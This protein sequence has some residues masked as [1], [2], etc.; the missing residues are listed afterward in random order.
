MSTRKR[1]APQRKPSP[2]KG[3]RVP[4]K[5][6]RK[7]RPTPQPSDMPIRAE[8]RLKLINEASGVGILEIS[9]VNGD[10]QHPNNRFLLTPECRRILGIL[11]DSD[12]RALEQL[13]KIMDPRDSEYVNTTFAA[14]IQDRTGKT[15]CVLEYRV[16]GPS[17]EA[18]WIRST[19]ATKRDAS[20]TAIHFVCALRDIHAEKQNVLSL[21]DAM[22]R[23]ELINKA[24]S[25][26]LWDMT[27][28]PGA[29]IGPK[30]E[31]W[32][33]AQFRKM[34]GYGDEKDFAS[35]LDSFTSRL[36]PRDKERVHNAFVA[37]LKD[38]SGRTPYDIEYQLQLKNGDY[39]WFRSTGET[40]RDQNGVPLRVAGALKDIH[41]EKETAIALES[42]ITAAV[43]GDFSKRMSS[44]L[45]RGPMRTIGDSMNRLLDSTS[46]SF[47][48][49]KSAIEQ[50]GQASAQLRATSQMMSQSSLELN[51]GVDRSSGELSRVADGVKGNAGSAVMANQ[52]V[53]ETAVAARGGAQRMEEMSQA[54]SAI[55]VSSVQIARIIKVI[56]EIAFQTNLL[57]LNAAVEAARA[58]R[59]G[60]GFAVVAQ[61]V[62]SLA[63][64]S[65][66]AAKETA[67]L[68]E[69]S[70]AKVDQG[71]KIAE[72]TRTALRNI[73]GNVTKVVDLAG[74]IASASGEQSQALAS[75][76][77]SMRQAT[78]AAQAGS[79][80][81]NE[82]AA[83]ADELSRQMKLLKERMDRYR[84]GA[85][86][87]T[88]LPGLPAAATPELIDQIIAAL[89]ARAASEGGAVANDGSVASPPPSS[90]R[91]L[92][93]TDD[94]GPRVALPLDRDERGFN[95]F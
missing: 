72:S 78:T 61:E 3:G 52:L 63:E 75:V 71:V 42:L 18:R 27:V 80:Q 48:Y 38:Q 58:G 81:S 86:A 6:E 90:T 76:T 17:G 92:T 79:Q 95:G 34:I 64:R 23:F 60:R 36:H 49:V 14:H 30:T 73:V 82:V 47:R 13:S 51:D 50:V 9:I 91:L 85:R 4:A 5:D 29:P 56:D 35:V 54:M 7:S 43:G 15:P 31:F 8:D 66:K 10:P 39:R 74:E 68:I 93:G 44:E 57:A 12:Q 40:L 25:V 53:T 11:D 89:R 62:R 70:S 37:H 19:A 45:Y 67:E 22:T 83:A 46:D 87:P 55:N 32:W 94:V 2:R 69:D 24:A 28:V 20:G 21:R 26:G 77:E 41:E 65:A 33:S 59:H 84:I 1:V 16:T 88:A